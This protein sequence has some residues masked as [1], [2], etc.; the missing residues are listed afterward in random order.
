M[1]KLAPTEAES[2]SRPD[3]CDWIPATSDCKPAT[4]D[5]TADTCSCIPD[6]L[7]SIAC[8]LPSVSLNRVLVVSSNL[9]TL[10]CVSKTSVLIV[11]TSV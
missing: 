8:I 5:S 1:T 2:A 10:Y 6:I 9:V 11:L 3:T 7:P 4:P